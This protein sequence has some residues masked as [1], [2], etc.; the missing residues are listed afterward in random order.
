[1]RKAIIGEWLENTL[2]IDDFSG[3]VNLLKSGKI[4][5]FIPD[6]PMTNFTPKRILR[7]YLIILL[8]KDV[9]GITPNEEP[10]LILSATFG[11]YY[12]FDESEE[13]LDWLK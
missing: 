4:L 9:W 3:I 2:L 5:G 8:G 12:L 11:S 7:K 1:M 13:I 10:L 6:D